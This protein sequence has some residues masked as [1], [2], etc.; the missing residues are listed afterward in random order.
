M[1]GVRSGLMAGELAAADAVLT[2][3]LGSVPD[4]MEWYAW[5][6]KAGVQGRGGGGAP[7]TGGRDPD[8]AFRDAWALQ[9]EQKSKK[10]WLQDGRGPPSTRPQP[11]RRLRGRRDFSAL[12]FGVHGIGYVS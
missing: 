3:V 5:M 7:G 4:K 8:M 2:N 11:G 1:S 9:L 6:S 12:F 10:E